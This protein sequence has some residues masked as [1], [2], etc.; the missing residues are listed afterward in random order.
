MNVL[1]YA[2]PLQDFLFQHRVKED[3]VITHTT[4][5]PKGK[6]NIPIED[7]KRFYTLYN[8]YI[9]K[10][11]SHT[12]LENPISNYIP[13]IVDIDLKKRLKDNERPRGLLY[14]Q[15]DIKNISK[16]FIRVLKNSK[17]HS[18]AIDTE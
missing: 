4:I 16:I 3:E 15:N 8:N 14:E 12:I 18:F 2:N 13:V 7:S 1:Y 9:T 5:Q 17:E 6:Y 10:H 11:K